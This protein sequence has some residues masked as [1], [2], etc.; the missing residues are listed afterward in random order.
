M[1]IEYRTELPR[2]EDLYRLYEQLGW[3]QFLNLNPDQLIKAMQGSVYSIYAY[4]GNTLVGTGR[5]VSDGIMIAYLCGLGV[6][7]EFRHRGIGTAIMNKLT[8]FCLDHGL[9]VQFLCEDHLTKYYEQ[10]GFVV[11]A[12]G[13][14]KITV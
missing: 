6:H 11:F 9:T 1:T 7:S 8:H 4:S 3:N 10:M 14:T 5:V 12:S 13:M 2:K